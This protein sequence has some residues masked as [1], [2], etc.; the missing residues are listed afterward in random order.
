MKL[1]VILLVNTKI[2]SF[3]HVHLINIYLQISTTTTNTT[4]T[5]TYTYIHIYILAIDW[6]YLEIRVS[7]AKILL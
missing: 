2:N 6:C 3:P 4:T 1:L 5:T 7:V